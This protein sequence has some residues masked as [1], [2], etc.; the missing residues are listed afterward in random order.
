MGIT[1][2]RLA[3]A[4][5]TLIAIIYTT[6][7]VSDESS[8]GDLYNNSDLQL[9]F[10]L[11]FGT[12]VGFAA[13]NFAGK[14]LKETEGVQ[15]VFELGLIKFLGIIVFTILI[16]VGY[17]ALILIL[18]EVFTGEGDNERSKFLLRIIIAVLIIYPFFQFLFLAKPGEDSSIPAEYIMEK[19]MEFMRDVF[20]SPFVATIIVYGLTYILPIVIILVSLDINLMT[21]LLLWALVLPLISLGALAGAG[22]GED[23]IRIRLIRNP[24]T[25]LFKLGMPKINL[26]PNNFRIDVGGFLLVILAIQAILTTAF[27]GTYSL[28]A[29]LGIITVGA[30]TGFSVLSLIVALFN[31]GRG[32]TKE[33][34]EVWSE[35]GFKV[36]T[37]QLFLP[38]YVFL[39]VI[40]SG[41]LEVFV[42]QGKDNPIGVLADIGLSGHEVLSAGMLAIQNFVLIFTAIYIFR[43]PPGTAERRLIKE[44]PKFYG[45]D[46]DGYLYIYKKL[47]SDRSVENLLQELARYIRKNPE[48]AGLLKG[49]LKETLTSGSARVQTAASETLLT[50]IEKQKQFDQEYHELVLLALNSEHTGARIYAVRSMRISLGWLKGVEKEE[51]I[52]EFHEKLRDLDPVISW[53]T[54]LALQRIVL[55]EPEYRSFI[56]ALVIKS[57]NKASHEG[58]IN[59]ISRFLHRISKENTEVGQMAISILGVQLSSGEADNIDNTITGIKSVIRANPFLSIDLIDIIAIGTDSP[60]LESR[61]NS[62]LVLTNLAEYGSGQE[63]EI[64]QLILKGV[65]DESIEIQKVAFDALSKDVKNHPELVD[66]IFTILMSQF[67]EL[68]G[69]PLLAA[70]DVIGSILDLNVD[71]DTQ[72]FMVIR[73]AAKS[74]TP[75]VRAAVLQNMS[76]IAKKSVS[77]AESIYQI[78]DENLNHA[79]E[80]VRE[81]AITA[82][83][84]AVAGDPNLARAVYRKIGDSRNDTS[85]RVQLASVEALGHVAS[86]SK[87]FSD[88]IFESLQPL[89]TDDDW[90]VRLAALNGVFAASRERSDLSGNLIK[91]IAFAITDNDRTVRGEALDM[92]NFA[93]E[94][95]REAAGIFLKSIQ[96]ELTLV[97]DEVKATLYNGLQLIA[98]KRVRLAPE[99]IGLLAGNFDNPEFSVRN[100]INEVLKTSVDKLSKS[101]ESSRDIQKFLNNLLTN[102]LKAANH[103]NPAVRKSAY[104]GITIINVGL[105]HLKVANRGR[106]AIARAMKH[107]KDVAL[108]DFLENCR[109]R[110]V[111]P[112]SFD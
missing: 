62:F 42:S 56:L 75:A 72:A 13:F 67:K 110:S 45:D 101:R 57:L 60:D 38:I 24:A 7:I 8:G 46:I 48:Q 29:T 17:D 23:L 83:G 21:A 88:E 50:I 51:A 1:S 55:D 66:E 47:K 11:I 99:V 89:L 81:K 18:L 4:I 28:I 78:A 20:R 54:S 90:Q 10:L 97:Q 94:K 98:D 39:G 68:R 40:L 36:S 92:F 34:K 71:L 3:S 73:D 112:L 93:V 27:F 107:E 19:I 35:G 79:D 109:V 106:N 37:F 53:D 82:M 85:A 14:E 58:S 80:F 63:E 6:I 65:N 91:E 96:K 16:A 2:P 25:D 86:A 111:P 5:A 77:L 15:S 30:A 76:T 49:L 31:K 108:A 103:S 74:N 64:L 9:V 102:I 59:A 52:I 32:S 104:E 12:F 84:E 70:L 105:P 22:I 100:A 95:Y 33:M 69:E 43:R 41:A 61:L 44:V 87:Q 26:N